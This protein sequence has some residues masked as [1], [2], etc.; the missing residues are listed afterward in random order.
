MQAA[1]WA[2]VPAFYAGLKRKHGKKRVL[3]KEFF[4][5]KVL[6]IL[7]AGILLFAGCGSDGSGDNTTPSP[8]DSADTAGQ[9]VTVTADSVSFKM[10]YVPGGLSFRTNDGDNNNGLDDST[11]SVSNAYFIG[12]TEVSYELWHKVHTWATANGYVFANA[13]RQGGNDGLGP[14]GTNQHPVTTI[15]WRDNIVWC[16]A[17]TEWYNAHNGTEADLDVVYYT[18]ANYQTP[19][20]VSTNTSTVNNTP[21]SEDKPYIKADSNSNTDMANCIAKGFRLPTAAEWSCAA[22]YKGSNSSNG[23]YEYP[24]GS[25][26]YWTPGDYASG[27]AADY[28]DAG[29]TQLVAVYEENSGDSTAAVKSRKA[30]ALGLFDMSGNVWECNFDWHPINSSRRLARGGIWRGNAGY[31]RVGYWTYILPKDGGPGLGFRFC[32]TQ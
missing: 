29:A 12:E 5:K 19:L 27:A 28:N 31:S 21:G 3:F 7:A 22:R 13:G 15:N 1:A 10:A 16:N 11:A 20:R 8:F 6:F 17:L 30:N 32:R 4:M 9:K 25:G 2:A 26:Y 23:A 24:V 14:V 18:N